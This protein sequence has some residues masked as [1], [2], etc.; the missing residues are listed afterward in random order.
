M[1]APLYPNAKIHV[2]PCGGWAEQYDR[3]RFS[4]DQHKD[5]VLSCRHAGDPG[6]TYLERISMRREDL[7]PRNPALEV[8]GV[9]GVA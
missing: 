2:Q 9:G 7:E 3:V 8:C 5:V 6:R 1:L 4:A